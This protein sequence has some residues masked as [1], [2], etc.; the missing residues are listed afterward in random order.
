MNVSRGK[1]VRLVLSI[2]QF[3]CLRVLSVLFL[4][5]TLFCIFTFF[6]FHL[7]IGIE[8]ICWLAL[9]LTLLNRFEDWK[10]DQS[11]SSELQYSAEDGIWTRSSTMIG[12]VAGRTRRGFEKVSKRIKSFRTL[13]GTSRRDDQ[14]TKKLG[15][16]VKILDPQGKFLQ[17]WNKIFV[18]TCFVAVAFDP[19][20]FYI[21]V[22]D[23]KRKCLSLDNK[24][25]IIACVLRTFVDIFYVLH[26]LFQF[27][28]GFIA[29]SSRV[30]G[31][32][33]LIDDPYAIAKKYLSSYFII[34]VLSILPLPQVC[35]FSSEQGYNM[36][37]HGQSQN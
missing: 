19:L 35:D 32:G 15:S 28:T 5:K 23:S 17:R 21:P 33:E 13:S 14:A 7:L 31:R 24:L 1:F 9:L 10:S 2:P 29:P 20:F 3:Q 37:R 11:L 36:C 8:R 25:D 4:T 26:I 12:S 34:D 18:F 27:R 30:F 22:I 6:I 16:R